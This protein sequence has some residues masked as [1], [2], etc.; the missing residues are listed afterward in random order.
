LETVDGLDNLS[1]Q[2]RAFVE[3][4]VA[5]P[6]KTLEAEYQRR[7]KAIDTG[8]AFC[9]AAEGKR[10]QRLRRPRRWIT[11]DEEPTPPPKRPRLA[12][13][14]EHDAALRQAMQSVQIKSPTQRP[15]VCFLC[16]G[17]PNVPLKDRTAKYAT[18][19][20]LT[21]HFMQKHVN[22][23]WPAGRVKCHVCKCKPI[24]D[25]KDLVEHAETCHGTVVRG[26][27]QKKF[28]LD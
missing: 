10:T 23:P 21:R 26:R 3:S 20:S 5:V 27:N 18:P 9:S 11:P 17:N 8:V 6:G 4:I 19:G 12:V 24:E 1:E 14:D 28:V 22:A 13:E 25:K 7:I 15:T 2:H 16:V